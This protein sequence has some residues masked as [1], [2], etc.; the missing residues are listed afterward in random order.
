M[1]VQFRAKDDS[2]SE[3]MEMKDEES[4][5]NRKQD[6]WGGALEW[7]LCEGLSKQCVLKAENMV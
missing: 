4:R 1:L 6:Y 7:S 3:I 2:Q 5:F